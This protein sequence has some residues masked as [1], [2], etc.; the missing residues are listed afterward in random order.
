LNA[1]TPSS[2]SPEDALRNASICD[3]LSATTLHPFLAGGRLARALAHQRLELPLVLRLRQ[4]DEVAAAVLEIEPDDVELGAERRLDVA[5]EVDIAVLGAEP[6]QRRQRIRELAQQQERV[7][8][9][10]RAEVRLDRDQRR[11]ACGHDVGGVRE[12]VAAA[13]ATSATARGD[14]R[15]TRHEGR[16]AGPHGAT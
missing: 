13:T 6:A 8:E 10:L 9:L 4:A 7:P 2:L 12:R 15:N 5:R 11:C 14:E 16:G 3:W 1:A